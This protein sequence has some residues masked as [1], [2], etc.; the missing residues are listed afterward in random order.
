MAGQQDDPCNDGCRSYTDQGEEHGGSAVLADLF[1]LFPLLLRL[2]RRSTP[3]RFTVPTPV[4]YSVNCLYSSRRGF[5][6]PYLFR[7][8]CWSLSSCLSEHPLSP[9]RFR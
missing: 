4:S 8:P 6:T 9:T 3:P 7:C 1:H 5:A 2:W